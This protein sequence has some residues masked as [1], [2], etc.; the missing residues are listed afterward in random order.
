[1]NIKQEDVLITKEPTYA[2]LK[3]RV[4]KLEKE[5]DRHKAIE[6]QILLLSSAVEQS[7]EGIAVVDLDGNLLYLNKALARMHGYS[8]KELIG[9]NLSVFHLPEHMPSV[10]AAN[11][12]IKETGKFAGEILNVRK[13]GNVFLTLMNNSIL[14]DDSGTHIGIIGTIRDISDIKRTEEALRESEDLFSAVV[15][16]ASEGIY[17]LDP[18]TKQILE[19]NNAFQT[20]LG[21]KP[22]EISKLKIYDFL[23]HEKN[24]IDEKIQHIISEKSYFVGERK[25]L[26]KDGTLLTFEAKA[27]LISYSGKDVLCV[28]VRNITRRKKLEDQLRQSKKMEAIG[29]LAGGI[30]H[31]FNNLLMGIQGNASLLKFEIDQENPDYGKA[32]E[33]ISNIEQLIRS[34]SDLT[35]QLLGFARSGKYETKPTDINK[36]LKKQNEI[37]GRTKKEITI[38]EKYEKKLW[39]VNVDQGQINQV[40]LNLFVNAWQAMSGG[41]DLYIQTENV[42]LDENYTIPFGVEPGKFV[43]ISVTDNGIGMDE[44]TLQ[45]IFEPF[46]T[47]KEISRG[48]GLGLASAYGII[49]N[50]DGFI[51]VFSER[52]KGTTLNIYLPASEKEVVKEKKPVDVML[53][54]TGTV[55]I[56][57]DEKMIVDAIK[58][59]I[60][61]LGYDVIIAYGGVEAIERFMENKDNINI[62]ILDMIMPDKSGG[63]T[64]DKL[65]E[66]KPD[67]KVLLSSGYSINGEAADILN[68]GCNGF[69]QKPFNVKEL[70]KKIREIIDN[71]LP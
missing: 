46:F 2:K 58:Q 50:H 37:F 10:E 70:S 64:F 1:M 30:A 17:L 31:D 33:K 44:A 7:T 21:Y 60:Q 13:D 20:M 63:Q 62:V 12:Q 54:G 66:I 61:K 11:K 27:N 56:V 45:R 8:Q 38:H 29:T 40:M 53:K 43:K 9:K 34:G 23:V 47:T 3:Q 36:L 24:D 42:I 68:R 32:K 59:M 65:K 71:D 16:Q 5:A 4:K 57:D 67:I 25:Y 26:R 15:K 55:L 39:P 22:E 69:I 28:V 41:G 51:S 6:D 35:G 49:K 18:Y 14:L 19:T 48:V 52:D